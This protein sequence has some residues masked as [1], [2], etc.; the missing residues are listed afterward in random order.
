MKREEIIELV[1]VGHRLTTGFGRAYGVW[2]IKNICIYV[3]DGM[4]LDKESART[5]AD[6]EE[7]LRLIVRSTETHDISVLIHPDDATPEE[8]KQWNDEKN[9]RR[10]QERP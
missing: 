6:L 9:W 5:C 7:D 3:L 8:L 2:Q 1:K 4:I 10:H